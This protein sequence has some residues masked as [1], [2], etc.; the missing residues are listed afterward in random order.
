MTKR[1]VWTGSIVLLL[2]ICLPAAASTAVVINSTSVNPKLN[3]I[4]I[5][6]QGFD[7]TGLAP[8]V[9][10]STSTLTVISFSKTSIVAALPP[11]TKA[12]SY[13]LTVTNSAANTLTFDVT[14]GAVGP[15]GPAGVAGP[16][17]LTG[18]A[19][20]QGLPG[21]Q[22]TPGAQGAAGTAGAQGPQGPPVAFQ[23][24]WQQ[25]STY[26]LG[27]AVSFGGS[28]YIS[29]LA[30]NAGNQPDQ[31]QT[32]WSLLAQ[33]G[34]AGAAGPQGPQGLVGAMGP[35]GT[36]GAQGSTGAQGPQGTTGAVGPQGAQGSQGVSGPS[37]PT[38]PQGL[39]GA[40]NV[41][42][43]NNQLLGTALDAL[44]DVFIPSL[45]LYTGFGFNDTVLCGVQYCGA[46]GP[47]PLPQLWYT[48][49]DCSG[50]GITTIYPFYMAQAL[51]WQNGPLVTLQVGGQV[52]YP[53]PVQSSLYGPYPCSAS[54]VTVG[55]NSWVYVTVQPFTATL[56][57]TLPVVPPLRLAPATQN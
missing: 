7:P 17:G 52:P 20:Q 38:G 3:Q 35:Q 21:P 1:C 44:G 11:G 24:G 15:Q 25:A 57:F 53:T 9:T 56:P 28:S 29:L 40:F 10:F 2:A 39:P 50:V 6:G 19:G 48:S 54:N 30:N 27:D 41:Y 5:L 26:N 32:Q 42:D 14:V 22:G 16:Q 13:P 55:G 31:S 8:T 33:Q 18:A 46:F 23:G 37:G 34:T 49:N 45:G 4:T 43:A 51:Y 12:G 47:T 36:Q